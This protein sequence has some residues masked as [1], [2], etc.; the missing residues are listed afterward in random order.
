MINSAQKGK[1]S[2][3]LLVLLP[4]CLQKFQSKLSCDRNL[5]CTV[6]SRRLA[7]LVMVQSVENYPQSPHPSSPGIFSSASDSSVFGW[8]PTDES[9]LDLQHCP[10]G[11]CIVDGARFSRTMIAK[12]V[13]GMT[14]HWKCGV[15]NRN[16]C[17]NFA[18][19][20][21]RAGH[22]ACAG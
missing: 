11:I 10:F 12:P 8:G 7:S 14:P 21:S 5:A 16:L 18:H 4:F 6:G 13:R 1:S 2:K 19:H 15:R 22:V 17:R 20:Y 9:F 3:K